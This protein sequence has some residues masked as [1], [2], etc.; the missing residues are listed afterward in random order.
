M[1]FLFILPFSIPLEKI[2]LKFSQKSYI[3]YI[4]SERE[5]SFKK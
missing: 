2:N 3:I 1:Q 5:R 4:E